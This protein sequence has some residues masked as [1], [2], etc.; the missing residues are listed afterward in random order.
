MAFLVKYLLP[1][2]VLLAGVAL[3]VWS[4]NPLVGL[5][6]IALA[7]VFEAIRVRRAVRTGS[8]SIRRE[9]MGTAHENLAFGGL[10]L[11][12]LTPIAGLFM[13]YN[14]LI[15]AAGAFLVLVS[16][17]TRTRRIRD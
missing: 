8:S 1:L 9:L 5:P 7:L 17:F 4:W 3:I 10:G 13:R 16:A 15:A 11:I 6:F 2:V 12:C 14:W